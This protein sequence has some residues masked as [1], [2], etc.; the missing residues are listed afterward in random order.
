MK[1]LRTY[2]VFFLSGILL[3]SIGFIFAPAEEPLVSAKHTVDLAQQELTE[4]EKTVAQKELEAQRAK[5]AEQEVLEKEQALKAEENKGQDVARELQQVEAEKAQKEAEAKKAEED[6]QEAQQLEEQQKQNLKDAQTKLTVAEQQAN[7][8]NQSQAEKIKTA[9]MINNTQTMVDGL[10]VSEGNK[11]ESR[12]VEVRIADYQDVIGKRKALEVMLKQHSVNSPEYKALQPIFVQLQGLEQVTHS[13]VVEAVIDIITKTPDLKVVEQKLNTIKEQLDLVRDD[14]DPSLMQFTKTIVDLQAKIAEIMTGKIPKEQAASQLKVIVNKQLLVTAQELNKTYTATKDVLGLGTLVGGVQVKISDRVTHMQQVT[15][16]QSV[17]ARNKVNQ[18]FD[19]V[20]ELINSGKTAEAGKVLAE[21][22]N[23]IVE[24]LSELKILED[25]FTSSNQADSE[26]FKNVQDEIALLND[27]RVSLDLIQQQ[28]NINARIAEIVVPEAPKAFL[29]RILE[30]VT[31]TFNSLIRSLGFSKPRDVLSSQG[32]VTLLNQ[33]VVNINEKLVPQQLAKISKA[34]S[35]ST[36]TVDVLEKEFDILLSKKPL[37]EEQLKKL[38]LLVNQARQGISPLVL[39]VAEIKQRSSDVFQ[40]TFAVND[41]QTN[42]TILDIVKEKFNFAAQGQPVTPDVIKISLGIDVA[43]GKALHLDQVDPFGV[44]YDMYKRDKLFYRDLGR[45]SLEKSM[46]I[47]NPE[48]VYRISDMIE[49]EQEGV[50]LLQKVE[51]YSK[52]KKT[53]SLDQFFRDNPSVDQSVMEDLSGSMTRLGSNTLQ[54]LKTQSFEIWSSEVLAELGS[55]REE[56]GRASVEASAVYIKAMRDF[57]S[58][59]GNMPLIRQF[60]ITGQE[61]NP[62]V[63]FK[64]SLTAST[65]G[66]VD[67]RTRLEGVFNQ[68]ND[69]VQGLMDR[70]DAMHE[71]LQ[72]VKVATDDPLNDLLP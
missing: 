30:G 55:I 66:L 20:N 26:Q 49:Q 23:Q 21:S 18:S 19:Q 48:S 51:E 2:L 41:I 6:L 39:Q 60:M 53:N 17:A 56:I 11:L 33:S 67:T 25:A 57:S 27:Q 40:A 5:T 44:G 70:V 43:T 46:D 34:A 16:V 65:V 3:G 14:L 15:L 35:E 61:D 29:K 9:E 71:N 12:S 7:Q 8:A 63:E 37:N 4:A 24:R 31:R 47:N 58:Y 50:K 1:V 32:Q 10:I 62:F 52:A 13:K 36:H 42:A 72:G 22:M 64:N 68:G 69:I 45:Q 59:Y 28:V 38:E 54:T